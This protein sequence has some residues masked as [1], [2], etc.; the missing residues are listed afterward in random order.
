MLES[1]EAS[2]R[3]AAP[4]A[5]GYSAEQVADRVAQRIVE[6]ALHPSMRAAAL[7]YEAGLDL[8][9]T[10]ATPEMAGGLRFHGNSIGI[11][12]GAWLRSIGAFMA[13]WT[14]TFWVMGRAFIAPREDVAPVPATLLYGVG[15]EEL[16]VEGSDA[17]FVD[18]CRNGPL[19]PL[20]AA[21]HLLVERG[22]ALVSTAPGLVTYASYPLF[23]AARLRRPGIR[24]LVRFLAGQLHAAGV[25]VRIALSRPLAA[26]LARDFAY[27]ALVR[28]L[29]RRGL[30]QAIMVTNSQYHIQPLW[31]RGSPERRF[32]THLAWY[33]QNSIP[34]AYLRDGAQGYLPNHRHILVDDIWVWTP[35]YAAYLRSRGARGRIHIVG[36]ILWYLPAPARL[37]GSGLRIVV[38]DVTPQVPSFTIQV[39]L[40]YNYYR[41]SNVT[42]F[43]M[44]IIEVRDQVERELG[45]PIEIVLKHKRTPTIH[46]D[47][48]YVALIRRLETQGKITLVPPHANVYGL[49]E[50]SSLAVVIPYSSP[51]YVADALGVPS[52]YYDAASELVPAHEPGKKIE[53]AAGRD[54]LR[55]AILRVLETRVTS[56]RPLVEP[57]AGAGS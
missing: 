7:R 31:M 37:Q 36:P 16:A 33:S 22:A 17:R 54:A 43:V 50:S 38:F 56:R 4:A 15:S 53:F 51:A 42:Q 30:L 49:V 48:E 18:F 29:D 57:G 26:I 32:T 34:F 39:G 44:D 12:P 25:F 41:A 28:D 13:Q 8:S 9:P 3:A 2:V 11:T 21:K 55:A 40:S 35:G 1:V 19:Q 6:L 5:L 52:I 45:Q 46:H 10:A 24:D 20:T 27:H 14:R 47:P 23:E